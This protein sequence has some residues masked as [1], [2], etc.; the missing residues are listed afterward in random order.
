MLGHKNRCAVLAEE[1]YREFPKQGR[2]DSLRPYLKKHGCFPQRRDP[3]TAPIRM[4]ELKHLVRI[5]KLHHERNFWRNHP[6]R[7]DVVMALTRHLKS[8]HALQRERREHH[9]SMTLEERLEE[10]AKANKPNA[11]GDGNGKDDEKTVSTHESSREYLESV[12]WGREAEWTVTEVQTSLRRKFGSDG[13][14]GRDLFSNHH[15]GI[16]DQDGMIYL[17]RMSERETPGLLGTRG[18]HT[19]KESAED[20]AKHQAEE[21]LAQHGEDD[22]GSQAE[23]STEG[24]PKLM[25]RRKCSVALLNMTLRAELTRQFTEEGGLNAL[26]H[27]TMSTK[28]YDTVVNCAA[29]LVNVC[30]E[31]TNPRRLLE[32]GV[33]PVLIHLADSPG[34]QPSNQMNDERIQQYA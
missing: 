19:E 26:L 3:D 33:L 12:Y 13:P 8:V 14:L 4:E 11:N 34:T 1:R 27:L 7:E 31:T 17:S 28:D 6:T 16:M 9:G 5:W 22:D 21:F 15:A 24:D 20:E 30:R 2:L 23:K 32:L 18:A 25:A 29:S 10:G